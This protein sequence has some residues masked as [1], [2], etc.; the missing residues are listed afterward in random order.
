M[1]TLVFVFA[2]FLESG[3]SKFIKDTLKDPDFATGEKT[4]LIA[5][6]EGEEEYDEAELAKINTF[7]VTV[8]DQEDLTPEFLKKCN[9]E[10]KPTRI[11]IEYNGMWMLD[12]LMEIPLPR[13]WV[14]AQVITTVDMTT[15]PMYMDNMKNLMMDKF[16]YADLTVF[17]RCEEDV[18]K[19]KYRRSVKAVNR[20]TEIVFEGKDGQML[21]MGEDDVPFDLNADIISIEDDDF[22]IWYLD[23]MDHPEKYQGKTVEFKAIVYKDKKLAKNMFAAGRFAMTCCA[24]DIAYI[25]VMCKSDFAEKLQVRDWIML[26]ARVETEYVKQYQAEGPVLYP[27]TIEPAQKPEEDIVYFT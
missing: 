14:M 21:P 19:T 24:D 7:L 22:G 15:C 11:M 18:D 8:E 27:I 3:K 16:L 25:G 5:C 12:Y 23:A 6:E 13:K 10:Y 2:G 9:S 26:T 17:N 4:L 1:D 20:R